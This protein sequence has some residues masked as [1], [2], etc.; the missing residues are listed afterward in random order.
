[1]LAG[2]SLVKRLTLM[3]MF[4]VIAVLVVAGMSFNVL[5]QHH[6]RL[7]DE[8]ALSEKLESARHILSIQ[9][10]GAS[11]EAL[12]LQLRAL[13][14]AHQDLTAEILSSNGDVL[15]SDLKAVPIPDHYKR[16]DQE[17]IWEWQDE[18][19]SFRGVTADVVIQGEQAPGT[20][21]LMLD[22]TS[23]AHF[24][25]TL[26]RWFAIGLVISAMVSAGLGWLVAKSGLRPVEQITK[27]ATSMSAGSLQERIP[28]EP[29]PL[30]LQALILSFNGMLARLEDAFVRLSNFSA[31][32][33]HEL[34][35]PVSNLLTH[36]EVVLTRKRDLDAYEDNLYS[37][38]EELKRMSRMIDDMLFL[39]NADNGLITPQQVD[40]ELNGLVSKLFEFYQLLAEDRDIRLTLQGKGIVFGDRLMIDRAVSN[41]LSNALRYTPQGNEISVHIQQTEDKVTLT[42]SN[43]GATI[44]PQHINRIFDRFYR[45]DPARR[46]GG[47]SNAGLGLAITRSIVQAHQG[48]VWCTSSEQM[49]AFHIAFPA[50]RQ[51]VG[52]RSRH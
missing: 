18:S 21:M 48:K 6:F 19:H 9:T 43:G 27:V 23:H 10:P 1:M 7:L 41:I 16:A 11:L 20:I 39:A 49:T 24:F 3:I 35:T 22:I 26:Q 28:L 29:V 51:P 46:E 2:S 34:R 33:A 30:E 17:A 32:I 50:S 38:L 14:G 40:I 15:F 47:P 37:N 52:D 36:T 45:A 12:R 31:D 25:E 4:A 5:S 44:D 13:L 8:Q 42:I